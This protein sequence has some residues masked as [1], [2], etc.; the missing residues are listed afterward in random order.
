MLY[1]PLHRLS[2]SLNPF[3]REQSQQGFFEFQM[4]LGCSMFVLRLMQLY[5]MFALDYLPL[6]TPL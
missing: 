5:L 2:D 6:S 1:V 3:E 4:H